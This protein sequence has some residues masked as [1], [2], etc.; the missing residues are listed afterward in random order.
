MEHIA[1][2]RDGAVAV[3][4]FNRPP[5]NA[6][7]LNFADEIE[8]AFSDLLAEPDLGAIVVTGS[9]AC[10]SAGLDLKRVPLY[11]PAEQRAMVTT[12]NRM[13]SR[14]Y[15]APLPVVG[16]INGHAIA[17]G[18]IVALVCDYRVG[19]SAPCKLG[20]TEARAGIP[21]PAA[22]MTVLRAELAP[23]VAR[24]LAL[25]A[26]NVDP[27]TALAWGLVD[28]LQ[29]AERVLPVAVDVARGLARIPR[30]AY[31]RIK[32]QLRAAAIAAIDETLARGSDPMLEAWLSAEA[33][34]ASAALLRG[35]KR[36]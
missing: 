26:D 18:L 17:G 13:I 5:A 23:P 10:F 33:P 25:R 12:I 28:E 35:G 20:V 1:L 21:F 19:S 4:R 22:A 7:D 16:A 27:Q 15:A 30:D 29:P 24:V 36:Q 34:A 3:F 11:G 9:G 32:R 6:I 14:L 31:A 8:A 2:E